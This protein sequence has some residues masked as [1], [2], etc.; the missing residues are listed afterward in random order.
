MKNPKL[1]RVA[2][3]PGF[4][5]VIT[6]SLMVLLTVVAI[7]LLTL[8][9]ITLRASGHGEAM[10]TA[11]AN[12]RMALALAIGQL[13]KDAGPDRRVTARADILGENVA[14]PRLTGVWD[15][16][17]IKASAPPSGGDFE[18]PAKDAKFRSWLV[19]GPDPAAT[20]TADFASQPPAAPV[21]LWDKGSLGEQAPATSL[22][23]AGKIPLAAPAGALAWAVLDEGVKARVNTAHQP[24]AGTLAEKTAQLATGERPATEFIPG[25]EGLKREFFEQDAPELATLEKGITGLN[26][27]FAGESVAAGVRE[28]LKPLAHDV[29]T[30]SLG[31]FTDT[32]RGGLRQ[33]FHLL[34][35]SN[36]LPAGYAGQGIYV[37]RLGMTTAEAPSDPTWDSLQQFGRLYRDKITNTGGVPVLKAQAPTRWQAATGTG[38]A[39][40]VNRKPPPGVVLMPTIAKVQMVFSLIGRD[41]Y[42]YPAFPAGQTPPQVPDSAT[43][44]HG[45][46]DGHFRG[47]KYNYDLHLL[48]TPVVTLHNPYNVALEFRSMRVE[49]LHVPFSMQVFRD[50]KPQSRGLVP[51]EH[52]YADNSPG[53]AKV[54]GMNLKT[55]AS[56]RPGSTTFRL[57]PGEVKL[58]SPYID[59]DRTYQEDLR[60]R[61]FW[62]IFVGTGITNNIDAIP[63]WRGDGI[64][65]DCDWIAGNQ[66]MT[67]AKEDGQWASCLGLARNDGIHVEFA[68]LSTTDARNKFTV[69][70]MAATGTSTT[71]TVVNA[72]EMDYESL[73]GL[74]DFTLGRNKTL[75]FP[76]SG[77][78][79]GVDLVDHSTRKV[80]DIV[81]VKP[82]AMLSVQAKTTAGGRDVSNK[83]GRLAT[84]PWCFAHA[85]IGGSSQ[86]VV[87]EHSA[88]HS[89]EFDFQLLELG[90][91]TTDT[92]PIDVQDR[93]TFITGHTTL[94]GS[95]FGVLHDIP[96]GPVRTL[97]GLNGANPGGS[98]GYLPR[99]AQPIGNS[100][101]HPLL[102]PDRIVQSSRNGAQLDHSFL[103]N[104]ALYDS[105]YFSGLADQ[106]GPFGSGTTAASLAAG[107]A[108]GS[109]LDDPRLELHR[110]NGRPAAELA[111]LIEEPVSHDRIAAWQ[112]MQG[113]FN[114]N[115]TSVAAW[116]AMLGSIHDPEAVMNRV[117][118][119]STTSAIAALPPVNSGEARI[120]RFR[121]PA[122]SSAAAGADPA[123]A[124]WL[125]PR[126]FTDDELQTL[127]EKIVEQVRERGPFLSLAEFVN[128]R[129]S[130]D[131]TAQRGALQQAID[132]SGLNSGLAAAA[133]AGF[134]IPAAQVALY[135]Y[136]N[137]AAGAGPSN[138]G[139]PGFL[140]QADL[141]NVLGNAATAR[142]DT[143]VVRGHGEARDPAGKI[144]ATATCEAVVQ[145]VPEWLDPADEVQTL[146]AAL[147]RPANQIFGRRFVVASFRWLSPKEI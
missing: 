51:L 138:Q 78:V 7:G 58:F 104:L 108:E 88:N 103:L 73:T 56:G 82:F 111:K 54:F 22:V 89:H 114:I 124:Y 1:L 68:P 42:G 62:D 19:S 18:K 83:D 61:K 47:T 85:S 128:R 145:R 122:S 25:L 102:P 90:R 115:S 98:S 147:T 63:G 43:N 80:K 23:Q 66:P 129:L 125:G 123:L 119:A 10:A 130:N 120:S 79:R 50:G 15:S 5:L 75:R 106:T 84:K 91:G 110:P 55:K 117:A 97:A 99:F 94:Y 3:R 107:F 57:L 44:M 60:D 39:V 41:I 17:E 87:S 14:N 118:P 139:A 12:A 52:M 69:R 146:P 74:Q 27:A 29:T 71:A 59:P 95:K 134:E 92:I 21:T 100:W 141:L 70:M 72:I 113:A 143:F 34:T 81:N 77:T 127:A 53:N 9:A 140:S 101:A 8:S 109:P 76:S 126:E 116:K 38:T 33:D 31:L 46:Q 135:K 64:G 20:A 96:L 28:A 35:Q 112:L 105:Y 132:D 67:G 93:G 137:P 45:P 13:Q 86:K 65:F 16:W 30:R 144:L 121:L 36:S 24:K 32:A 6:L 49:F 37:S 136:G 142:S 11:R 2:A 4:A 131:E 26:Y 48:Y 40:T 133:N